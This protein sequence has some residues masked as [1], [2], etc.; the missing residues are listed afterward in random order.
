VHSKTLKINTQVQLIKASHP[1]GKSIVVDKEKKPF[2][3]MFTVL[4][5]MNSQQTYSLQ[6]ISMAML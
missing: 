4:L 5:N 1:A 3:P 2:G 6:K